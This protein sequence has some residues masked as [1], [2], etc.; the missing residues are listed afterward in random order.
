MKQL[1]VSKLSHSL[2][3]F[4]LSFFSLGFVIRIIISLPKNVKQ[5]S[6]ETLNSFSK[7]TN[8]WNEDL[9]V[10]LWI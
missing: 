3:V 2:D 4:R 5:N 10:K 9:N 8:A 1:I 6:A 7:S